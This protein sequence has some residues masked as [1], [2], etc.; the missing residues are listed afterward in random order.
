MVL[1]AAEVVEEIVIQREIVRKKNKMTN[2]IFDLFI[3]V[4]KEQLP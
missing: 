4:K 3:K 1:V 2:T